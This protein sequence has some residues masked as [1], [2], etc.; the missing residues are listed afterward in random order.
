MK[1]W[2]KKNIQTLQLHVSTLVI[3]FFFFQTIK[4]VCIFVAH[5]QLSLYICQLFFN[6]NFLLFLISNTFK[7]ADMVS[8]KSSSSLGQ[9]KINITTIILLISFL[10][11][12]FIIL[13]YVD[14]TR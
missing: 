10:L 2:K 5:S 14:V 3:F 6:L 4:L 11:L 8:Y 9:E 7:C 1:K 13:K 12:I